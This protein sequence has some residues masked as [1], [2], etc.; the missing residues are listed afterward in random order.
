MSSNCLA[1]FTDN[2]SSLLDDIYSDNQLSVSGIWMYT[3][4]IGVESA[5]YGEVHSGVSQSR[6][7][8]DLISFPNLWRCIVG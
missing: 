1:T 7:R 5:L 8:E 3:A 2:C 4:V 6:S